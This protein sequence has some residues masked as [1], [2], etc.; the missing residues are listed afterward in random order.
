MSGNKRKILLT[1]VAELDIRNDDARLEAVIDLLFDGAFRQVDRWTRGDN[2][3]L[4]T[5]FK[6]RAELESPQVVN[7]G[8]AFLIF[9][10]CLVGRN[11]L[12]LPNVVHT[13][14]LGLHDFGDGVEERSPVALLLWFDGEL[15][16]LLCEVAL[17]SH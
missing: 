14:A 3:P 16:E 9:S 12:D 11:L 7:L 15:S 4:G 8:F 1:V 17:V 2:W 5:I 10:N 6:S 13:D